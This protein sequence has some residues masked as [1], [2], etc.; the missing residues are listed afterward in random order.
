MS[1]NVPDKVIL[2]ESSPREKKARFRPFYV[3]KID[4]FGG[5][6]ILVCGFIMSPDHNSIEHVWDDLGKAISQSSFP[7]RTL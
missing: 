2:I 7:P 6:G 5:K 3:T 1:Q 4:R